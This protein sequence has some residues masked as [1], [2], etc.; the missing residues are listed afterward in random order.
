[1]KAACGSGS[2]ERAARKGEDARFAPVLE[3]RTI[4]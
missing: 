2:K 4:K 1:V 3:L